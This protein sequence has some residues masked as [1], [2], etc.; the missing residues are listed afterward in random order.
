MVQLR[1]A[2]I[3]QDRGWGEQGRISSVDR[4]AGPDQPIEQCWSKGAMM[5]IAYGRVMKLR[6]SL[7]GEAGGSRYIGLVRGQG[8]GCCASTAPAIASQLCNVGWD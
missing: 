6:Q 7:I 5:Q 3:D 4:Q 2:S 1:A 8:C